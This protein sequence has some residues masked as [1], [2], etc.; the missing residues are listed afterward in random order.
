MAIMDIITVSH[1]ETNERQADAMLN[2][3]ECLEEPGSVELIHISNRKE[4]RGFAKACNLG[5]SAGTSQ[6]I[7]FLNPDCMIGGPFVSDTIRVLE[8]GV[9]VTGCR[10]NKPDSHLREWGVKEWVC[11]AAFF[12]TRKHFEALG[13]FD[14]RFVWSFEETDFIRRTEEAG[15]VVMPG[16]FT[17]KHHHN[18]RDDM[19]EDL[20]YKEREFALAKV[21][22]ND[23]WNI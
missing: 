4:N 21:A 15:G 20:V 9:S 17:I 2:S 11:G 19:P 12:T 23:K 3:V 22:Y 8:S 7:G 6:Y 5:V 18:Q 1:N 14:E 16:H 13:G 10:F